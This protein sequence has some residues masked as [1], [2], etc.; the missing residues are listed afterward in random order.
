MPDLRTGAGVVGYRKVLVATSIGTL[1]EVYDILIYG[2]FATVLSQR[3]FPPGDPTAA[4]LATFAIFAVGFFVRP[5][6]AVI[7]GHVGDR[8]GRRTALA[9]SLLLM[10]LA[11]VAFG[12]LPT[13]AAVGLLAPVLLLLC[14]VLQGLSISAEIPGAML[15]MLEHAPINR[16]GLAVSITTVGSGLGI[17]VAAMVS[18]VLARLLSPDQ[19]AA[20]G[21]RVAFLIAAPI[22]IVGLYVRTRLLDSPAFLA[23]GETA[24]QGRAPL[25]RAL[26]T[27]KRD[28]LVL[29]VWFGAQSIA[30]YTL[31]VLMPS[32]LIRNAGLPPAE[33]YAA[34]LLAVLI[35][36][37]FTLLG[38]FL[39]DQFPLRRVAIAVMAG[40]AVIAVPGFLVITAHR[41]LGAAVIGQLLYA[42]FLG[43]V[44]TV[45][46]VLALTLFPTGIRF[47]AL[48]VPLNIG[49]ALF[50]GTAP[51]VSTWLA[52]T[53]H[54]PLAPG[55]YVF[56]AAT[57]GTLAA[58]FGLRHRDVPTPHDRSR[59]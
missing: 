10:T 51:Y 46:A 35:S 25:V 45:G 29:T 33:A 28:M 1:I 18:L 31:S 39:V 58:I 59:H 24:R 6:G 4:L 27:A 49:T 42:I 15:L 13:Y 19:L 3:F 32:Y 7:F 2:Y 16:R 37:A 20:W 26:S 54:S 56:A 41:T 52:A 55:F 36:A 53:T 22:G 11:T 57:A 14:R 44:Y 50:G 8:I 21:W 40:T 23:L 47:T 5:L 30:G 48:A 38:G 9:F 12:L 34:N 17:V 43:P